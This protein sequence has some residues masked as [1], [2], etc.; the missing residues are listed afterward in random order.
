VV[1]EK[2]L[3]LPTSRT[4]VFP[5]HLTS[6]FCG[7]V[8]SETLES[9][10]PILVGQFLPLSKQVR[11]QIPLTHALAGGLSL[12]LYPDTRPRNLEIAALQ[13]GLVLVAD[14]TELI[15]EGAGFGVPIAKYQDG[16]FFSSTAKVYLHQ[17]SEDEAVVSKVF[18]LDAISQK[19]VGSTYVD[20][21]LYSALHKTFEKLYLGRLGAHGVFDWLMH[22]RNLIGVQTRF[23]QVPSRG[24]LTFTYRCRSRSVQVN[25]DLSDLNKAGCQEI[26]ILNEQGA[27]TFRRHMDSSGSVLFDRQVGGWTRVQAKGAAFSDILGNVSFSLKNMEGAT[28]YRGREQVKGRFSWAGMTYAL[29]PRTSTFSYTLR[30]ERKS[31]TREH[32][33]LG[34]C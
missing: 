21:G 30:V 16:T 9:R 26:L 24:T 12:R 2:D 29:N 5:S 23:V 14:G 20:K 4:D 17:Q 15:E 28:L 25:V 22:L 11:M 27:G 31:P 33:L 10:Q 3:K 7:K 19:Q 13:K 34:A 1:S 18:F 6:S 32:K 8:N